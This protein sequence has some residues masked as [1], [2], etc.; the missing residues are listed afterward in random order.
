VNSTKIR[1]GHIDPITG[2]NVDCT[3]GAVRWFLSTWRSGQPA[4]YFAAA[5]EF[6]WTYS[7]EMESDRALIP[8][9]PQIITTDG[10]VFI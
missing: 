7:L 5:I 1:V 8:T 2:I 9:T 4:W 3:L 10:T 6:A